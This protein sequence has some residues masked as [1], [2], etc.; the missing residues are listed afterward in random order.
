VYGAD[1][2]APDPHHVA[3]KSCHAKSGRSQ[4]R[5]EANLLLELQHPHVI[6]GYGLYNFN[7]NGEG[8]LALV[9]DYMGGGE[10][11]DH[12][13]VGPKMPETPARSIL[14]Q[15]FSAVAYV[16]SMGV[17]HRDIKLSNILCRE[18][19][20]GLFIVLS[21]F[22]L[23]TLSS[24]EAEMRR[25]CGS[26]GYVAP[27][28]IAGLPYDERVDCFSVGVVAYSVLCGHSPFDESCIQGTMRSNV[29][30][31]LPTKPMAN[32]SNAA[33]DLILRLCARCPDDR[34]RSRDLAYHP[35]SRQ[36]PELA[37]G[38]TRVGSESDLDDELL[39]VGR[40]SKDVFL[41]NVKGPDSPKPSSQIR[42]PNLP[43]SD[44]PYQRPNRTCE[45]RSQP[46]EPL[47]VPRRLR[48]DVLP[49]TEPLRK[50]EY[51][52]RKDEYR[53]ETAYS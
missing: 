34:I 22:G 30:A 13:Q 12:L 7:V 53:A 28:M 19:R 40:P 50:H 15:L 52:E 18:T 37:S 45:R 35:W 6:A 36:K 29:K 24:N 9:L 4:L 1:T 39:G 31:E 25:R 38:S 14:V 17:V 49:R 41:S 2:V 20:G 47:Q 11:S 44:R 16:H 27:E 32:L 26:P 5:N 51:M 46:T 10:L 33:E 48:A 42:C 23:A 8:T 43:R 3:V 21:D